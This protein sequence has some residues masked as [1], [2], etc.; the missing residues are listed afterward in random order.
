M[1]CFSACQLAL[2]KKG[3]TWRKMP[4]E[5]L[6]YSQQVIKLSVEAEKETLHESPLSA[7]DVIMTS[8]TF[9]KRRAIFFS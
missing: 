9:S 3:V 1:S 5:L 6:K 4:K 8:S 2:F 7:G